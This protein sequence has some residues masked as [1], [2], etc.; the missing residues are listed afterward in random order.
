MSIQE[1]LARGGPRKLLALDGGGIR[2]L[3]TLQY[4]AQIESL[5]RKTSG[6]NDLVLADY[7]DYV[8]GTS[9]GGIIAALIATGKAVAEIQQFYVEQGP[10]MFDPVG[11]FQLW[12]SRYS[13]DPLRQMLKTVLGETRFG[14]PKLR[15]LLMLGMRN[16]TTDSPWP[17]S[18]N[19][20]ATYNDTARP[21]NNNLLPLW[22]LVRA[23]TAAP[24]YFPPE[25]VK[26]GEHDFYFVDGGVTMYN[27]PALQLFLM[28]TLEPYRLCWPAGESRMLLVSVGT[29]SSESPAKLFVGQL[30]IAHNALSVPGALMGSAA[31]Q[32]DVLC[33]VLGRCLHGE[34]VDRE[35]GDLTKTAS[36]VDPRLFTYVRYN[37]LLSRSSFDARKFRKDWEPDELHAM[38]D[39][40]NIPRLIEVGRAAAQQDVSADHF[41]RFPV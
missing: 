39:T 15:T 41:A 18:N 3:I 21:D 5:L 22:Q 37:V 10:A 29:G 32:Q 26:L 24:T 38:D 20:G 2:G 27:N 40:R 11:L 9:T 23:S 7:F 1:V 6:R 30:D 19:P 8:A 17:L 28:A 4:L 33:R 13:D 31:V 14:E 35:I 25:R 16:A 34:M 36:P 12:R